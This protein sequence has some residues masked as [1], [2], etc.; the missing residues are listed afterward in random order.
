MKL[1]FTVVLLLAS[2]QVFGQDQW[3]QVDSMNGP[4][5]SVA[6]AFVLNNEAYVVGGLTA[7]DFTRKMYSF[8][9]DQNDW[10]DELSWGGETGNGQNRGSSTSF[11]IDNKVYIG[12]G[13]GNSA[14]YYKDWWTYDPTTETWTQLSDFIGTAR[15]G[16]VGFTLDQIGYL[17]T[18]QDV[19]GLCKDF[20]KYNPTNNQWA[21][22]TD[23]NGT[24]RKFAV[25]VS[26]GGEA[27]I[28]FGDDGTYKNDLWQYD[29]FT[30]EWSQKAAFPGLGRSG[31]TAWSIFP[32]L[33]IACGET[34]NGT[35]LNEV[36]EYNF[37]SNSWTQRASLPGLVRKH[38]VSF[39]IHNIA[40]VGSGYSDGQ[41]LDDF[42]GYLQPALGVE[43]NQTMALSVYP[44]PCTDELRLR[45]DSEVSIDHFSIIDAKGSLVSTGSFSNNIDVSSLNNGTY[46]VVLYTN[47]GQS[48]SQVFIKHD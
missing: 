36:W 15:H 8:N 39:V 35:S 40:Y 29:V 14:L 27:Y 34:A 1:R 5:K 25:G 26:M 11:V 28:G 19:N 44:N 46:H 24:A 20:F 41:F 13:Q 22:L 32:S 17:G 7:Q 42:Y 23:F 3:F 2:L 16:A 31:A 10:D 48:Y 33:Y 38:P 18:G 6:N 9:P 37:W 47:S 30:D 4:G 45:L 12:L 43:E 21:Q